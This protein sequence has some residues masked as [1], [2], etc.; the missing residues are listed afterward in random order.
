MTK[1][2]IIEGF[3]AAGKTLY[4]RGYA[5]GAAGNMSQ[6][7]P[8]GT[9]VATPTGSCLGTLK[10]DELSIVDKEGK[11]LSGKKATKEV[12]FHLAIYANNPDVQAVVHLHCCYCTAYA[13][14]NNLDPHNAIRP[15][16]PYVVMRMGEVPL[17]PY[18][19]PGSIHL[20]EDIAKVAAGHN[21]FL[22]ANHGMITCGKTMTE[23]VNN[24]EEL[25]AACKLYFLLKGEEH[26]R[27]LSEAEIAELR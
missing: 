19:K 15:V 10:A 9:V 22:M 8:D 12:K 3:I 20:A 16:T 13:C 6:L 25:E 1:E 11:L 21:A 23:A 18:Y 4:D 7:L 14:L 24:A 27:Y 2:E 17:I 26:V 5:S